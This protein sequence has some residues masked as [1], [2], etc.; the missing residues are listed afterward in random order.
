MERRILGPPYRLLR[1]SVDYGY[2]YGGDANERADIGTM[3]CLPTIRTVNNFGSVTIT[4]VYSKTVIVD[5]NVTRVS[6]NGGTGGTTARATPQEQA[7][8]ASST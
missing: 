5:T 6:F 4:N 3:E 8:R 1:G 7:A 2:G